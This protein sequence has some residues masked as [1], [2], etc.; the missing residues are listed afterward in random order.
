MDLNTLLTPAV[1]FFC[2]GLT[3]QSLG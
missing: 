1:L 3:A 2:L